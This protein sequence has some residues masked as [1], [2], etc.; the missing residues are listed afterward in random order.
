M[1]LPVVAIARGQG[2]G[3]REKEGEEIGKEG[4]RKRKYANSEGKEGMG[5]E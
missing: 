3:G 4:G 2:R 5:V 1:P